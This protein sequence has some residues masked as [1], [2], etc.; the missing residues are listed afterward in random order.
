MPVSFTL[1]GVH[2]RD[3][4][5]D[6]CEKWESIV[7]P[8]ILVYSGLCSVEARGAVYV[9]HRDLFPSAKLVFTST[10]DCKIEFKC[11]INGRL[12]DPSIKDTDP[13]EWHVWKEGY[14]DD[15][16]F[17][18][19]LEPF[20]TKEVETEIATINFTPINSTKGLILHLELSHIS[21]K[22]KCFTRSVEI[23]D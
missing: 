12:F 22:C 19:V 16:S 6:R 21:I 2:C 8:N 13:P 5:F 7:D 10:S 14:T 1:V 15:V 11:Q 17:T 3:N 4:G 23:D 18:T 9:N 20:E